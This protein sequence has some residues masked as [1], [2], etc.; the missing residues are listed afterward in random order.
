MKRAFLTL[1][2]L[3]A[4]ALFAEARELPKAVHLVNHMKVFSTTHFVRGGEAGGA[5]GGGASE[6]AQARAD[7]PAPRPSPQPAHAD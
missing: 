6:A 7:T 5:H 2:A 3:G 1:V 4:L